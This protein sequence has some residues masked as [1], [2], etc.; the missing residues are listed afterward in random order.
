MR[1]NVAQAVSARRGTRLRLVL[2]TAL[3]LVA[4]PAFAGDRAQL[5]VIGYS[6]DGQYFAFEQYGIHDGSGG[7]YSDVFVLDLSNDKWLPGVPF[8]AR[9]E[10]G[11]DPANDLA[12]TRADARKGAEQLIAQ[13]GI[14]NPASIAALN[15]DG[16]PELDGKTLRFGRPI[17][18][19]IDGDSTLTLT[20]VDATSPNPCQDYSDERPQGYELTLHS[21]AGETVLHVDKALPASRGCPLEYS[22][23]SVIYPLEGE[24][25]PVAFISVYTQGFEGPDRRFIAL[26]L[27]LQ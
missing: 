12:G 2:T 16:V 27:P 5:D 23:Y 6:A 24:G 15:G 22:L 14:A 4:A 1:L 10:D 3:A 21:E 17:Y 18:S 26:P 19:G 25:A 9:H 11:E 7:Y 8:S 13:Y 20:Q